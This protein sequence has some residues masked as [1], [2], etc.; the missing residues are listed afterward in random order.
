V[1]EEWFVV[2][3][4]LPE[5]VAR[6]VPLTGTH[7]GPAASACILQPR[8]LESAV[9]VLRAAR[10]MDRHAV[11]FAGGLTAAHDYARAVAEGAL[12]WPR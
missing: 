4:M 5:I 3:D 2:T 6:R 10:S 8:D 9:A 1:V 11:L 12:A 7:S